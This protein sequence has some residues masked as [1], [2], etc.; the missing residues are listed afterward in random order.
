MQ[1]SLS[2]ALEGS[3]MNHRTRLI[4]FLVLSLSTFAGAGELPTAEPD[5]DLG[6]SPAKSLTS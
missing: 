1:A 5:A 2:R 6:L 4:T 3:F